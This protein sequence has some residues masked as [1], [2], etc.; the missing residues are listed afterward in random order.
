[1]IEDY[2]P[3]KMSTLGTAWTLIRGI[4]SMILTTAFLVIGNLL[5]V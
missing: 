2:E 3:V 4:P 1:M 5:A